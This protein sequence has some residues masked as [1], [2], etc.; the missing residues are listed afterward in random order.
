MSIV[1][2]FKDSCE[3]NSAKA[4]IAWRDQSLTFSEF[5][6]LTDNIAQ[7]LLGSGAAPGDRVALHLSNGPEM[8]LGV[9]GCLK[10]GCV[11]VPINTRLKGREIDYVL[12]HSEAVAYI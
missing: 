4:A 12:R 8:A 7:N 1:Q 5:D 11:L 6:R 2:L 10:A 9:F 3:R